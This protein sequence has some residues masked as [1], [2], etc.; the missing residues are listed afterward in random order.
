MSL[1]YWLGHRQG[2]VLTLTW[3]AL[4]VEWRK[5]SK[6]KARAVL[7]PEA[8]PE[9]AAGLATER[10]RQAESD[11]PSTHVVVCEMTGRPWQEDTFRHEFRRI[12]KSAGI[13]HD[14]QFRDLRA[15]AAT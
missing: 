2:D 11:T 5:T 15:T 4:D 13:P 10:A 3:T 12:A 1:A 7:V 9:L 6:T 8:Y 14:L